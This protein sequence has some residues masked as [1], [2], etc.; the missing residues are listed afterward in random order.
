MLRKT[1]L[2]RRSPMKRSYRKADPVT[3]QL[4]ISVLERDHGCVAVALGES[5]ADCAGR[6][7][8]DHVK[9]APR[10]GKRAPSDAAHLASVCEH[11][12]LDGWAT[13]HRPEL[14]AYL[15]AI[16]GTR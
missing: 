1:P 12:H 14:R 6:L 10:M 13:A 9:D 4:R 7:T 8:L 3:P 15:E 2:R 11:H 16:G 5:P